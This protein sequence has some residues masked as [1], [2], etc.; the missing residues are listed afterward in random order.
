MYIE[1]KKVAL[2]SKVF[3]SLTHAIGFTHSLFGKVP[4]VL[5]QERNY[6]NWE[7]VEKIDA[8]FGNVTL[9]LKWSICDPV[10]IAVWA[11]CKFFFAPAFVS[12]CTH[13]AKL[14]TKPRRKYRRGRRCEISEPFSGDLPIRRCSR[15][16]FAHQ[17][18]LLGCRK[19]GSDEDGQLFC[20]T[21]RFCKDLKDQGNRAWIAFTAKKQCPLMMSR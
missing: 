17:H 16:S 12:L 13:M 1:G 4:L 19:T 7:R 6:S 18:Q 5:N 11:R 21:Q 8:L 14:N 20:L 2:G 3:S 9:G 10:S 15:I